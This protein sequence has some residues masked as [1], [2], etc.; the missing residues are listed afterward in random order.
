[1]LDRYSDK[2]GTVTRAAMEAGL[3]A[4]FAKAD[5]DHDGCLDAD[6]ARAVNEER[7]QEDESAASPLIDFQHNGCIDF[8]E[9]A[10]TPR[11]LFDQL[12]KN[13]DGKLTPEELHPGRKP[14]PAKAVT[15]QSP[16]GT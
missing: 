16:G 8:D 15:S 10:A 11:S 1:M 6:E 5:V 2:N 13:G 9:F 14:P 3:R 4:D 7:W 12:D